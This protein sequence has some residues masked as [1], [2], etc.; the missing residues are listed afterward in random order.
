MNNIL[1]T[2]KKELR[3]IFRDKKTLATLF[4][5]PLMIPMMVILYGVLYDNIENEENTYTIGYN[6]ELSEAEES[7]LK[8]TNLE[9]KKYDSKEKLKEEYDKKNII[10]YITKEN[11]VY[12]INVN[13][14]DTTGM[15]VGSFIEAYF[16]TYDQYL[17]NTY[18]VEHGIDLEEAYTHFNIEYNELNNN[19]YVVTL[20]LA[21]SLTYI[22]LSICIAT[23]NMATSAT[24]TEKE[25]GT[26]ETI[27]TFPI[28]KTELITG[29][30]LSSVVVGFIAAIA[31][32]VLMIVSMYIGTKNY[33]IYKDLNLVFTVKTITIAVLVIL[34]A[35]IFI[36]GVS[37]LLTANA[38]T[39][40]EAQGKTSLI[41]LVGTVPMFVSLMGVEITR[42]YYL[43]PVCNY[44]QILTDIFTN[45]IDLINVLIASASSIIYTVFVIIYVIKSY[46]SEKILFTD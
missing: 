32:L 44:E 13:T 24:A 36:A 9:F 12:T 46:N 8:D 21:I 15:S 41:T 23:A 14:S 2:L 40:K 6:Y 4:I 11:D 35:S 45:N 26:L 18:L 37:Y 10:A 22:V 1:I 27:L 42:Y 17:T 25:N 28:K 19:N 30:Y 20:L 3:S 16:E 7:L 34:M 39:Y 38:K 5:Y 31:S 43:I 29:K 33:E